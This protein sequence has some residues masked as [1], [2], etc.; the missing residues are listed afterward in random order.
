MKEKETIISLYVINEHILQM[1]KKSITHQ[2]NRQINNNKQVIS[3]CKNAIKQKISEQT[4]SQSNVPT[5]R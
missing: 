3:V 1:S 5:N 4:N 2:S